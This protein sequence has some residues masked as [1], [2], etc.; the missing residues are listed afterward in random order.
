M[1]AHTGKSGFP[2]YVVIGGGVTGCVLAERLKQRRPQSSVTL[3][4]GSSTLG[5]LSVR[6]EP[7]PIGWDRFYHVVTPQ[8]VMLTDWLRRLGCDGKLRWRGAHTGFYADGELHAFD[9]P[10][11]FLRFPPLNLIEKSRLAASILYASRVSDGTPLWNVTAKQWL[12]QIAGEAVY[13]K[14]WQPLLRAKLGSAHEEVAATFIWSTIRRLY[15]TRQGESRREAFGY[16]SGGYAPVFSA[17]EQ[18]LQRLGVTVH[19]S[20][21]ISELVDN[22]DGSTCIRTASGQELFA[23]RVIYTGPSRFLPKLCAR[24]PVPSDLLHRAEQTRYLGVLCLVVK[25]LRPLLPYYIL[26]LTDA[27][28]PFTGVIGLTTLVDPSET[29]GHHLVYLPRYLPDD[30]PDFDKPDSAFTEPFL[31]ALTQIAR[32]RGFRLDEVLSTHLFRS[33]FVSPIAVRNEASAVL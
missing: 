21:P 17:A 7:D 18:Y 9:T 19:K 30:D 29:G 31:R 33:R 10:I 26:N 1:T 28:M 6:S 3:V 27:G 8:D 32:H 25:L 24:F 22:S 23:D 15:A 20:A 2:R 5:G 14:F 12:T 11:D 13:R 4:E 16:I